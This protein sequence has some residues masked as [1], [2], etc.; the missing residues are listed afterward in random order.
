M[1]SKVP[2]WEFAPFA[3]VVWSKCCSA[4]DHAS[5]C[6]KIDAGIGRQIWEIFVALDVDSQSKIHID[7]VCDIIQRVLRENG[8]EELEQNIKEWFCDEILIDFWSFF[9]AIVENYAAL[10]KVSIYSGTPLNRAP[11]GQLKVSR[12]V[13][14]PQYTKYIYTRLRMKKV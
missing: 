12:I 6:S 11:L 5:L 13:R 1:F 14:C 10:L 8:H 3:S 9:T 7:D 4:P 2:G